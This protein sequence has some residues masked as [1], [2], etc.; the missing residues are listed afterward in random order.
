MKLGPL[1]LILATCVVQVAFAGRLSEVSQRKGFSLKLKR[2]PQVLGRDDNTNKTDSFRFYSESTAR[3]SIDTN[4][5]A[6]AY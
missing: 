5:D 3:E 2:A 4:C 1:S 6:D